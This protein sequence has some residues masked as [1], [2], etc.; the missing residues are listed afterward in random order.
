MSMSRTEQLVL[1][2][3]L[4]IIF[5]SISFLWFI[6]GFIFIFIQIYRHLKKKT[7]QKLYGYNRSLQLPSSFL[8]PIEQTLQCDNI[9]DNDQ[10]DDD[11]DGDQTSVLTSVSFI[12]NRSKINH[13]NRHYTTSCQGIPEEPFEL[14]FPNLPGMSNLA[15]SK[16]TLSSS[17]DND[18]S[19]LYYPGYRNFAYSQSTLC[20]STANYHQKTP[21]PSLIIPFNNS[22]SSIRQFN[23]KRQSSQSSTNTLSSRIT[24]ATYLSCQ[25]S[26]KTIPLPTVMIT[27]V[28]RLQT[29]IIELENFEPEKEEWNYRRS[30]LRYLLNDRIPEKMK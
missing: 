14:I 6:I 10:I 26:I 25:S 17:S 28:D 15:Y 11:D 12:S 9:S 21:T 18:T 22:S 24:N 29:D 2:K 16:S 4:L 5:G 27:D 13:D 20:S 8:I 19:L 3:R 1:L 7:N 23:L 30:Q